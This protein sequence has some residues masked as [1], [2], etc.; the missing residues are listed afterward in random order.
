[1]MNLNYGVH[2]TPWS[3]AHFCSIAPCHLHVDVHICMYVRTY[4]DIHS[5]WDHIPRSSTIPSIS[6]K[7]VGP[8]ERGSTKI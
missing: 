6:G 2:G 7:F 5:S 1:M 4:Y 3:H 8:L